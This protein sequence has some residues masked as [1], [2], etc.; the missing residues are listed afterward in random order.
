MWN[1]NSPW[2]SDMLGY[3]KKMKVNFHAGSE[4]IAVNK[5]RNNAYPLEKGGTQNAM[6]V[7][8]A[9][10]NLNHG[11]VV[12][13]AGGGQNFQ[14]VFSGKGSPEA[15]AAVL[16]TFGDYQEKFVAAYGN[17]SYDNNYP[18]RVTADWLGDP[19]LS[20]HDTLQAISDEFIGL[21]CNGFV[22]NWLKRAD[23]GLLLNE[24]SDPPTVRGATKKKRMSLDEIEEW[25][26]AQSGTTAATSPRSR[27]LAP[28][29]GNSGF[30]S[31]RGTGRSC[32][33]I[34]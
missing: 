15:I 31:R 29:A 22:G 20:W 16:A 33:N 3:Y 24:Q 30:A 2:P 18:V 10:Y 28:P 21:D 1:E 7:K 9:L 4:V 12:R 6:I 14:D 11:D 32:K 5:Y 26:V 17:L 23:A 19:D 27:P 25:D 13:R 8:S 34:F